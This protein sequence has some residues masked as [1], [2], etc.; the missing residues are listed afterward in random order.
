MK[1]HPCS[2]E[3]TISITIIAHFLIEQEVKKEIQHE[4]TLAFSQHP[5]AD[6]GKYFS[7]RV[8]K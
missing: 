2:S 5:K 1:L 3:A 8:S 6:C 7:S 4:G